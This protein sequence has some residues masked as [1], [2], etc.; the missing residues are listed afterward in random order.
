MEIVGIEPLR[1]PERARMSANKKR[2]CSL[3]LALGAWALGFQIWGATGK[4]FSKEI[5]AFDPKPALG[6]LDTAHGSIAAN[7]SVAIVGWALHPAG[8]AEARVYVDGTYASRLALQQSRPDVRAAF[9]T[10]PG[11]LR[12][13]FRAVVPL[14][15]PLRA[16]YTVRVDLKLHNGLSST[17]GPWTLRP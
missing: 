15:L 7:G 4:Y 6:A 9:P 12:S 5:L 1:A 17:L 10:F 16:H 14:A 11:A 2:W 8:V 3:F 13:G